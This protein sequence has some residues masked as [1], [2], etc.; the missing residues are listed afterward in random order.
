MSWDILL[1][2]SKIDTDDMDAQPESMGDREELIEE[3]KKLSTEIDFSD[4]TWGIYF[5]GQTSIEI[6]I[7]SDEKVN[8]IMLHIRGGGNPF[9]FIATTCEHF[10]WYALDCSTGQYIDFSNPSKDS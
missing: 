4:K 1:L 3:F 7:G 8:S 10:K 2:K 9:I 5:D 6:N